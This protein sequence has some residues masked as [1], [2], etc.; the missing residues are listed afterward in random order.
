MS[1]DHFQSSSIMLLGDKPVN[2]STVLEIIRRQGQLPALVKELLLEQV[3]ASFSISN[4]EE[5]Q[6]LNKFRNETNLQVDEDY[7]DFLNRN[8]LNESLVLKNLVKPKLIA[9]FQEDRWGPRANSL[10]LK[11]KDKYDQVVYLRLQCKNPDIMQE[12]FFRLK[13]REESWESLAQQFN[14]GLS[15]PSARQGPTP[16]AEIEEP[17]VQALRQAG[18]GKVC[19]PIQIK[20][21]IL[22]V[23]LEAFQACSFN[24]D[25]RQRILEM[26]FENW[27]E[28]E[29]K[30]MLQ[31]VSYPT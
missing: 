20:D 4:E 6:L 15:Q 25:L 9:L 29:S 19:R 3:L 21:Q 24:N 12:V 22:V 1:V 26:E 23:Q 14:P 17:V 2:G 7:L 8:H 5:S 10:Y 27:V 11:N 18:P 30:K 13:D 31:K 16:V 28:E